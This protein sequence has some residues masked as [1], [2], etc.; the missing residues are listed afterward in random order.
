MSDEALSFKGPERG[1]PKEQCKKQ[2]RDKSPSAR[3]FEDWVNVIFDATGRAVRG[4][5][6]LNTS[7]RFNPQLAMG[8]S[9]QVANG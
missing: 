8:V 6:C 1:K 5:H 2:A 7:R 4:T 9:G 3:A